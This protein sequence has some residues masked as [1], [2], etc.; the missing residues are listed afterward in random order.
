MRL[1]DAES[2]HQFNDPEW[3][4]RSAVCFTQPRNIGSFRRQRRLRVAGMSRLRSGCSGRQPIAGV[5]GSIHGC[6]FPGHTYRSPVSP[7]MCGAR[8]LV[9]TGALKIGTGRGPCE[10]DLRQSVPPLGLLL[11]I[12]LELVLPVAADQL[13]VAI[14]RSLLPA[15]RDHLNE[16]FYSAATPRGLAASM[17]R[18]LCRPCS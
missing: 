5:L 2:A 8:S 7:F 12:G 15:S 18:G 6:F 14:S 11:F 10:A 9:S 17:P 4:H 3:F 16:R 1:L 13:S